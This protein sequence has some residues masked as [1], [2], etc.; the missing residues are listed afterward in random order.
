MS[1][2]RASAASAAASPA[3]S[4]AIG[5]SRARGLGAVGERARD[6]Q[7]RALDRLA[8]RRVGLGARPAQR[9]GDRGAVERAA[10]AEPVAG[11][12]HELREDD[13]RVA[14][15]AQQRGPRADP[16]DGGRLGLRARL[17]GVQH[18]ARRLREVRAGVAVG[19]REDV[20]VVDARGVPRKRAGC[21]GGGEAHECERI[22]GGGRSG[23][24][25]RW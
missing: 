14:A 8:Q 13:P 17:Q 21:A 9:I 7:D 11:A 19:H 23:H 2:V 6:R 3:A 20:D 5:S 16:R 22:A 25:T 18:R 4:V 24:R 1:V 15:R 10:L 12:A